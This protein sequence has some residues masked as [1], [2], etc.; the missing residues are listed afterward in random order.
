MASKQKK[1]SSTVYQLKITLKGI[2]PPIW[3]RV[4]V[5]DFMTLQ[6]LHSVIQA[7]MGWYDYHLYAFD[8]NG[9]EYGKPTDWDEVEDAG[10]VSLKQVITR[11]KMKFNY[12]YDFGDDWEHQILVENI[13][14]PE[15]SM[16]YP[17]C[18]GGRRACPPEDCGG[19]WGYAEFLE[20]ISN[21]DHPEHETMLEWIGEEFD[22]AEFSVDDANE[23]LSSTRIA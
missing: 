23:A 18:I 5:P 6:D 8:I 22:P 1:G 14:Q 7:V 10:K 16:A 11:E 9:V 4:I 15:P 3:R 2:R 20:A 21:P 17:R 12:T 19:V 13:L